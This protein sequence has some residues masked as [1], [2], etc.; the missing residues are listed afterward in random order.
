MMK[1]LAIPLSLAVVATLAACGGPQ[2]TKTAYAE[3]ASFVSPMA[4][5]SVRTGLGKVQVLTDPAGPVDA[6]SWQRMTLQMADGSTQ[7]VDRRGHQ[8]AMG[9]TVRV[10]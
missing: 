4:G 2:A 3:P 9:E 5:G 8:V 10:R 6:L 7:I 1:K